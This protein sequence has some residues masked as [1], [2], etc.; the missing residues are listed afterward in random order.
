MLASRSAFGETPPRWS[1]R[2]SPIGFLSVGSWLPGDRLRMYEGA[3][4]CGVAT[5]LWV[6]RTELPLGDSA[7]SRLLDRLD[8][9]WPVG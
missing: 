4:V 8:A 9:E 6:D 3:S 7:A 2:S 1:F 5:V